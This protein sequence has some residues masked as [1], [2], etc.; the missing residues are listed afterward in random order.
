MFG[1][2]INQS[3]INEETFEQGLNVNTVTIHPD[4]TVTLDVTPILESPST[5]GV[6][7]P[8]GGSGSVFGENS[9]TITT[10]VRVKSGETIMIGG[11]ITK[12]ELRAITDTPLLGKIPLLGPLLFGSRS[13]T[14][15]DEETMIFITP[16]IMKQDSTDSGAWR[17]YRPSSEDMLL[18]RQLH[19]G[20]GHSSSCIVSRSGSTFAP[21]RR[22]Q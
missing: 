17:H 7:V 6:P 20:R 18:L 4:D 14:T 19:A 2:T 12:N 8:G 9:T 1:R 5:T 10:V 16:T 11:F 3:E 15:T 22:T 21:R 13:N